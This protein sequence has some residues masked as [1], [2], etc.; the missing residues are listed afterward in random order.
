MRSAGTAPGGTGV[1][2]AAGRKLLPEVVA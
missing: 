2:P 1:P